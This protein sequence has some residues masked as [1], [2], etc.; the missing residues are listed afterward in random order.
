VLDGLLKS[1]DLSDFLSYNVF[2]TATLNNKEKISITLPS[3][4]LKYAESYQQEHGFASRSDVLA[5][6]LRAL[7]RL[8]LIESYRQAAEYARTH[9]DP[10]EEI[11]AIDGLEPSDGNEWL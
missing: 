1:D 4:L 6:G 11:D 5:E 7:R 3:E 8:E 9:P 10:L 2:M